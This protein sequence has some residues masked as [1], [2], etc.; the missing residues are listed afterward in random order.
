MREQSC[1]PG[2]RSPP[3]AMPAASRFSQAFSLCARDLQTGLTAPG[4]RYRAV[5]SGLT[6]CRHVSCRCRWSCSPEGFSLLL[7]LML[8]LDLRAWR[9]GEGGEKEEECGNAVEK[10]S[11][12]GAFVSSVNPAALNWNRPRTGS[13]SVLVH[14]GSYGSPLQPQ[15]SSE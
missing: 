13:C 12:L 3:A 11:S 1:S 8:P 7:P 10:G 5:S 4:S 2:E 14:G 6:A 15:G 9:R